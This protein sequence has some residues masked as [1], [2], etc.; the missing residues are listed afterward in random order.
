MMVYGWYNFSIQS[1]STDDKS[2]KRETESIDRSEWR[3]ILRCGPP[4]MNKAMAA[5]LKDLGYTREMQFQ[6]GAFDELPPI[7]DVTL[8]T[9]S[10]SLTH[11]LSM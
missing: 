1:R 5:H 7:L 4:P 11:I 6:F 3:I 2:V 8:F 9:A 10:I